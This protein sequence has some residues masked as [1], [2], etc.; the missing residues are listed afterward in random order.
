M[1]ARVNILVVDDRE[2]VRRSHLRVL[3]QASYNAQAAWDGT[4]AL[5]AMANE[6]FDVVMLDLRMP[7]MDGMEVL[8]VIKEKWPNAEVVVITGYPSIESAKQALRLGASQYL[9]KPLTPDEV[10]QAAKVASTH[11]RWTLRRTDEQ[12]EPGT[13]GVH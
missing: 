5:R 11:K 2:I 1:N 3:R 6:P 9:S 4:E 8:K 12:A 13:R 10:I 7:G